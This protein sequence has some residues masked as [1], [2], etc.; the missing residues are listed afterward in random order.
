MIGKGPVHSLTGA[1]GSATIRSLSQF[2]AIAALEIRLR[3]RRPSRGG[4]LS[5]MAPGWRWPGTVVAGFRRRVWLSCLVALMLVIV[6]GSLA[7]AAD[8]RPDLEFQ[9]SSVILPGGM[10]PQATVLVAIH[11][12]TEAAWRDVRLTWLPAPGLDVQPSAPL[13]VS[14]LAPHADYVW[15]L[16]VKRARRLPTS[17]AAGV[18]TLPRPA[19]PVTGP[20]PGPSA[21]A[22]SFAPPESLV[23]EYLDL[24][25]EYK[26]GAGDREEP[27]VILKSL[28]VKTQD[29]GDIDKILD[30]Q[31]ATTLESL[32]SSQWGSIDVVLKNNSARTINIPN[33]APIGAG[34]SFCQERKIELP[35][36][37]LPFCFYSST[38][39]LILAPHQTA[40]ED[41]P[42][43]ADKR[44]KVGKYLL[45]FQIATQW[46]EG[47]APLRR[48]FV[49]SQAVDVNVVGEP[50][51]LTVAGIPAFLLLPG[52]LLLLTIG[53]CWS[54]ENLWWP[55]PDRKEFPFKWSEPN[56]WLVSVIISL[57]IAMV[58]WLFK[59]RWYFTRYRLQDIAALWFVSILAGLGCY[60]VWW[61]YRNH[62]GR[63]AAERI[64]LLAD[65]EAA[66]LRA[67]ARREQRTR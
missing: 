14:V 57:L 10:G 5:A 34:V 11:N 53:L 59:N 51:I 19:G 18:T 50:A 6:L 62:R 48:N 20:A 56:F 15:T 3:T 2:P 40:V 29:V 67:R 7:F 12:P 33:V 37:S 43:K 46:S 8:T 36:R 16:T 26:T 42:V 30:V 17:G 32:D 21:V 49:I 25:L 61:T 9:P 47:G 55:A 44:V 22:R 4:G 58:P 52:T 31:I 54:L 39:S 63:Q 45:A 27:Q 28:P 65:A 38:H 13:S 60:V 66:Q 35:Y 1:A 23:D 41:F 64:S 24:R